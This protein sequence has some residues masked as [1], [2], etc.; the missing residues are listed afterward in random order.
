MIVDDAVMRF[1]AQMHCFLSKVYQIVI[2][3][4]GFSVEKAE[5]EKFSIAG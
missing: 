5:N 1:I 3:K 4:K 2:I